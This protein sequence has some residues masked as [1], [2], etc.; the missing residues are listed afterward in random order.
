MRELTYTDL[1]PG[2]ARVFAAVQFVTGRGPASIG[3]ASTSGMGSR[4]RRL[5]CLVGMETG[6]SST[7]IAA[8]L[9]IGHPAVCRAKNAMAR[10]AEDNPSL[11]FQIQQVRE[12][13]SR[14]HESVRDLYATRAG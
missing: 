11:V 4:A 1:T 8:A 9:G 10:K 7:E 5:V 2:L 12:L 3:R 6:Y 14:S 13:S